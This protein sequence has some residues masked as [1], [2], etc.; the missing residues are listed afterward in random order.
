MMKIG[1]R[2]GDIALWSYGAFTARVLRASSNINDIR[3]GY[4]PLL[5]ENCFV[6]HSS[7]SYLWDTIVKDVLC[8]IYSSSFPGRFDSVSP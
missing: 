6:S 5:Q 3:L 8:L 2:Y 1:T 7:F 4:I